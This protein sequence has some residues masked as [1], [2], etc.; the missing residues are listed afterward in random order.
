VTDLGLPGADR[1]LAA[2][3]LSCHPV[4]TVHS[5]RAVS[6]ARS[7]TTRVAWFGRRSWR[8]EDP[9]PA[10]RIGQALY[11]GLSLRSWRRRHAHRGISRRQGRARSYHTAAS[12][13]VP[14]RQR[15]G[16]EHNSAQ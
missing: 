1:G 4:T 14:R 16:D 15:Q 6:V 5:R 9:K 3:I 10:D 2:S 8:Q 7:R 13:R 12:D 11:Q